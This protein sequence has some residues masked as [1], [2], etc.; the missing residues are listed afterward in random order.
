MYTSQD[1]TFAYTFTPPV[2]ESGEYTVWAV[3][4]GLNDKPNQGAFSIH[5]LKASPTKYTLNIPK[6]YDYAI[7]IKVVAGPATD[8]T[9][10]RL[11]YDALDQYEGSLVQGVNITLPEP[12]P[13]LLA[14]ETTTL[15]F[16]VRADSG[17]FESND[18]VLKVSQ[19]WGRLCFY[20]FVKQI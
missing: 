9:N 2:N 8:A 20:A 18:L 10:L 3:H 13:V 15:D 7:S 11:A 17:A 6:N 19:Y 1:G 16:T 14:G 12:V 5:R 4:P